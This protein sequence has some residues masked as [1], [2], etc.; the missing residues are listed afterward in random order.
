MFPELALQDAELMA[1]G[2]YLSSELGLM[3]LT[4]CLFPLEALFRRLTQPSN[5]SAT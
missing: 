5:D 4:P 2:Q 1:E 3:Q